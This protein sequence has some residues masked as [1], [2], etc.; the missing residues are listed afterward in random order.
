MR[1]DRATTVEFLFYD[2]FYGIEEDPR[3]YAYS[4]PHIKAKLDY[5]GE[6]VKE[7]FGYIYWEK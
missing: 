7:V 6:R 5:L 1:E 2:E 4:H 3:E